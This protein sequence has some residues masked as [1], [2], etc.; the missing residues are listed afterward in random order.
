MTAPTLYRGLGLHL[1]VIYDGDIRKYSPGVKIEKGGRFT[2]RIAVEPRYYAS[3]V[4][5]ET[6]SL[7]LGKQ[8]IDN[9]LS[10]DD[11]LYFDYPE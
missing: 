1:V 2:Q 7:V 11:V 4:E 3:E 9:H 5:A 6:R 8:L 10:G